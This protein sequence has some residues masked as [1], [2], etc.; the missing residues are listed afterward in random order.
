MTATEQVT[1]DGSRYPGARRPDRYRRVDSHGIGLAVYEWGDE[2]ARPA[3]CVH[4]GLDFA[5]TWDLLA[6]LLVEGGWRVVAW[7]Q[8]GHGDSD[9]APLYSWEADIRD[10][11]A[12]L[13]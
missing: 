3:F 13:D 1:E 12:V 7:D 8:R 10:L 9:L 6:P 5:A 2:S 11:L 4:G